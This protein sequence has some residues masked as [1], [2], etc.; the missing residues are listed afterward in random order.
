[1]KSL[2]DKIN[3]KF[4]TQGGFLT[5]VSVLVGGTAFAQIIGFLC[6]P[7]LTRLYAPEDYSVLGVYIAIVSILSVISCLRFDIAIPIPREE[8]EGK[9]LLLLSLISNTIFVIILYLILF[10]GYSIIQSYKIAQQLSYWIWFIPLGV[11][12][13]GLY[14][15]L[16]F[17]ATRRKRFKDIAKTRMTQSIFGNSTS[18]IV[19][20]LGGGFWGLILGQLLNYSG[21]LIKLAISAKQD[22]KFVKKSSLKKTFI[23]YSNFPKYSTFEAL[24]N[25]SALQ[26]PLIIIASF[27][28]G[29]EVGFL[30]MAM[31]ILAIPMSLIGSAIAQIYLSEASQY[32]KENRLYNYTVIMVS[33]IAK[34]II[35]PFVIL[36]IIS[37]YVFGY[38]LGDSWSG[39]GSYVLIMIPW[40]FMQILVSPVS[41]ALNVIEKQ[42]IA[43]IIQLIGFFLRV[44]CLLIWHYLCFDNIIE[45]FC[46]SGFVFYMFYFLIVFYC[47]KGK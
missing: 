43:L 14:S 25:T 16:Q 36:A 40:F 3:A 9:A 13:V 1:M 27:L 34:I 42:R 17:W 26:L 8:K 20:S 39:L 18:L 22:L 7:I 6:L 30:M 44:V 5:A 38:F 47:L 28:G 10:L 45:F 19:G 12:I 15:T 21:G 31:K 35:L 37:P 29:A 33:R 2:L 4:S 24:A 46:I 41:M 32:Y 11:Y 23:K